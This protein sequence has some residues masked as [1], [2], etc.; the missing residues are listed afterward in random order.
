MGIHR[1]LATRNILLTETLEPKVSDFGMSRK[2]DD[3]DDLLSQKTTS[4]VGPLEWMA[5]E[6][7][8]EKTYSKKSDVWSYGVV[9]WEIFERSS[10][11]PE[12][13]PVQAAMLVV[14]E[15]QHLQPPAHAPAFFKNMMLRCFARNPT[16]R[17]EFNDLINDFGSLQQQQPELDLQSTGSFDKSNQYGSSNQINFQ[18]ALSHSGG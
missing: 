16:S 14:Y 1:D 5:P 4:D 18:Q 8:K 3:Q 6:S 2:G 11:W 9:I 7:I 17:P 15:N 10:P 12:M 13:T